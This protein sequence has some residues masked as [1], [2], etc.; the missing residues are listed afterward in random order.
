MKTHI[1]WMILRDMPEVLAIEAA[2][3]DAPWSKDDFIRVLHQ[4]NC[5]GL[6]V[7]DDQRVRGFLVYEI[8]ERGINILDFAV[9]PDVRRQGIGRQLIDKMVYKLSAQRRL[10]LLADVRET[11][12][13]AQLFLRQMGFRAVHILHGTYDDSTE[14]AYR[15]RYRISVGVPKFTGR[16]VDTIG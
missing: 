10:R 12:V 16:R 15:M 5:I 8:Q 7:D 1:R 2:S 6:V 11:N 9:S 4:R 14:D 13:G 3:F